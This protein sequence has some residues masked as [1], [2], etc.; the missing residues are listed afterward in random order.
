MAEYKEA[1]LYKMDEMQSACPPKH[2]NTDAFTL[3]PQETFLHR[4]SSGRRGGTGCAP[5][6][7]ALLF[8]AFRHWY[9]E[10]ER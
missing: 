8:Y 2:I 3:I 4:G 10:S 5:G 7:G 9:S 1:T 6:Q